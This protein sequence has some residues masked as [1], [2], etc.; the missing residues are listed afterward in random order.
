MSDSEDDRFRVKT[1]SLGVGG[2]LHRF[3]PSPTRDSHSPRVLAKASFSIHGDAVEPAFWTD[4]FGCKPTESRVWSDERGLA[5]SGRR[6]APRA[7]LWNLSTE[8]SISND[9]LDPHLSFLVTKLALPRL[10]L[11]ALLRELAP[12]SRVFCFW[13]NDSGDRVPDVRPEY[14]DI[15]RAS[16]IGFEIDEYPQQIGILGGRKTYKAWI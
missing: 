1:T 3:V 5:P 11:G 4:Y 12:K 9:H 2:D 7:G 6:Y 10:D 8:A 16:G 13:Q 14:L 15:F